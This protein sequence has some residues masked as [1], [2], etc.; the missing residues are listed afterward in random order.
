MKSIIKNIE[1]LIALVKNDKVNDYISNVKKAYLSKI[2]YEPSFYKIE[3]S[4]TSKY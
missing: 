1:S 3:P 2:G 4:G